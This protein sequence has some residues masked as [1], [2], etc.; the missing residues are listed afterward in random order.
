MSIAPPKPSVLDYRA[1]RPLTVA[2]VD[3]LA[4]TGAFHPDE[5]LELIQGVL[6]PMTAPG[7]QHS[8]VAA[9]INMLLTEIARQERTVV[10]PAGGFEADDVNLL[11]PDLLLMRPGAMSFGE[12][13]KPK[14]VLLLVEISKSSLDLDMKAKAEVYAAAGVPEYWVVDVVQQRVFQHTQPKPDGTYDVIRMFSRGESVA[15][16]TLPNHTF[17]VET[18]FGPAA[19]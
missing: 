3:R 17:P 1:L 19:S 5:R 9:Y 11:S 18:M 13:P 8:A 4:E 6:V 7:P 14:D 2:D 10:V 15:C 12:R 16:T